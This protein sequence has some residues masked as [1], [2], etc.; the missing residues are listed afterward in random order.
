MATD[1][2]ILR[3]T[4]VLSE[5]YRVVTVT[6]RNSE[7]SKHVSEGMKKTGRCLMICHIWLVKLCEIQSNITRDILDTMFA[8]LSK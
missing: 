3:A 8:V 5:A 7:S 6:G 1:G 4:G 2:S